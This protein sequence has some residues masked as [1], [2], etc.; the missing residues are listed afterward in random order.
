MKKTIL[1]WIIVLLLGKVA[2]AATVS[3]TAS[4]ITNGTF[5]SGSFIFP[6]DLTIQGLLYLNNSLGFGNISTCANN[7]IL[8]VSGG[9]WACSSDISGNTSKP[10]DCVV[11]LAGNGDYNYLNQ[12]VIDNCG[13]IYIKNGTYN[14]A[15]MNI[16][17]NYQQIVCEQG[18]VLNLTATNQ[19]VFYG[20]DGV[21]GVVIEGCIFDLGDDALSP[22]DMGG[23]ILADN[24]S[25]WVVVFNQFKHSDGGDEAIYF[26]DGAYYNIIKDNYLYDN[27]GYGIRIRG[28]A[29]NMIDHNTI[30][31]NH[32]HAIDVTV[33]YNTLKVPSYG[34]M[35]T[36]NI[37]DN[38][39]GTSQNGITV[40]GAEIGNYSARNI[41]TG[42][43]IN[44][45]EGHGISMDNSHKESVVDNNY[46][47]N[48]QS[49]CAITLNGFNNGS[50]SNNFIYN[51]YCGISLATSN[52]NIDRQPANNNVIKNN[53]ISECG[54]TSINL[55][56]LAADVGVYNNTIKSNIIMFCKGNNYSIAVNSV[57][58][59]VVDTLLDSNTIIGCNGG[60]FDNSVNTV[61]KNHYD[62]SK[63]Y[64]YYS[65]GLNVSG[66][67]TA[68]T[69]YGNI[70]ASYIQNAPWITSD[71]WWSLGSYLYNESGNLEL[72]ET[73]LNA[74]ID[75]RDSDT[76][77][78]NGSGL[79]LA[80]TT[81]S[82]TDMSSQSSVDN[83]GRTYIQ[84][85]SLDAW[86]R[87][88]GISSATETVTDT[89]ESTRFNNLVS[90]ACSSGDFVSNFSVNG[91]PQCG[92]PSGD[93]TSVQGEN[94]YI[95]NGA[96]SGAVT[97]KFNETKLNATIDAR[98][99]DTTYSAGTGLSLAGT[100]F[101]LLWTF[102]SNF[103][104]DIGYFYTESNLTSLLDDNYVHR[105]DWTTIDNYP[106]GCNAYQA[107]RIIGDTLTCVDLINDTHATS[108]PW[109]NITSKPNPINVTTSF[110]GDVSGT[111][112]SIVVDNVDC[113]N[114]SGATS[115]LCTITDTHATSLP[116]SNITS[117]TFGS[118][119]F[120]FPNNLTVKGKLFIDQNDNFKGLQLDCEQTTERCVFVESPSNGAVVEFQ[121]DRIT[122]SAA[123][124]RMG[125]LDDGLATFVFSRGIG[126]ADSASPVGMFRQ[127]NAT[128]DQPVLKLAQ[129]G[130]GRHL[131]LSGT[132]TGGIDMSGFDIL[133][134]GNVGIGTSN[135]S[136]PLHIYDAANNV[137][138][139]FQTG[140][141]DGNAGFNLENDVQQW[142]MLVRGDL[143]DSL[144]I[145]DNT[146]GSDKVKMEKDG[147]FNL[148]NNNITTVK[149][150]YFD[151]GAKV[152]N[153]G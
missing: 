5:G 42:N 96:D 78:T 124:T 20:E 1:I 134:A 14:V 47:Y 12:T 46:I 50:V 57:N 133:N 152:G 8:K 145:R 77:Y 6:S 67:I 43:W 128:D 143:A 86:G 69:F 87:V 41:V 112:N 55:R 22:N 125:D 29:E 56:R 60:V 82:L 2:V 13:S 111:Y 33:D 39:S 97:L 54:G 101:S 83:S 59:S 147:D 119:D 150:I 136:K 58:G 89:N 91:T 126:A 36:N 37:I 25:H 11:D 107:V 85:I 28:G 76:T 40:Y 149:C 31:D 122:S 18:T 108:L 65:I 121:N 71:T 95:Y 117:G 16:S 44:A 153:C 63:N 114:I 88:T 7:Q 27:E 130:T 34:V 102:L 94:I 142:Q 100:T 23:G 9:Q 116:A 45:T 66:N 3:H 105:S 104:D 70:N 118:G 98:D 132:G 80:G 110:G 137:V 61:F 113:G 109:A 141:T 140:K 72:N 35:I 19:P 123:Y 106:S 21:E 62:S 81:F 139:Y 52:G 73:K 75:A 127:S 51:D 120:T 92:T 93:I 64:L 138:A 135:P 24:A 84:D 48:T 79:T 151:N 144:V 49:G 53:I 146:G 129:Y 17:T 26:R 131:V 148:L 15:R 103:T 10:V 30:I 32:V 99:S 115:N 68:S 74:T 4:Q 90:F 38:V